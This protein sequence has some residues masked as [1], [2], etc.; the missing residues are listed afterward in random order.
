MI[1]EI[2]NRITSNLPKMMMEV[3]R[4]RE[5]GRLVESTPQTDRNILVKQYETF[6]VY[7]RELNATDI[8]IGGDSS[9]GRVWFRVYGKKK[10]K[11][12]LGIFSLDDT[13]VIC[14]SLIGYEQ[15]DL[16]LKE[17][18]LDFSYHLHH[19]GNYWR[20][21]ASMYFDLGHLA[22]NMRAIMENIYP[23]K[24]LG[25]QPEIA[26]VL[27]L[28][29]E[30]QGLILITG[31][32]GSGKST[33]LDSI[34]D[35]NNQTVDAHAVIIGSPIEKIHKSKRCI[36]RHRE[37]GRDVRSFKEGAIQALRQDPDIIVVGEMRDAETI[38]TCLEI[39]DTG[40]KVF[41]TLHTCSAVETLDR[42]IAECPTEEQ[43]R[44][45]NRLADVL[46]VVMSQKL[47][48]TIDGK[49]AL[50]KEVLLVTASVKAAIRN[51]NTHEIY[52]M[53]SEGG[54]LG[55]CTLEQDLKRLYVQRI[56][57]KDTAIDYANN[58][59]RV[60]ELLE[61]SQHRAILT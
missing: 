11:E 60:Q 23:F 57:T 47:V 54:A 16:L 59:K 55:M 24:R 7:M 5:I 41:S 8:E 50:A 39:T 45:R 27:S 17:R 30:K 1:S 26:R 61:H 51:R 9:M 29:H 28:A 4:Q 18:S 53:I 33:T 10:P 14:H 15:R 42:I 22:L 3:D 48:P 44:I 40:H 12:E 2:T 20:W 58:K 38:S 37:V 6:L 36:I 21:R 49:I 46:R 13:D 35:A 52:Q 25:I 34:I 43:D 56:I 19:N 32:T 31:I